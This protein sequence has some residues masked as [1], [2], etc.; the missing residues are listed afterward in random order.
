MPAFKVGD[1]I[2]LRDPITFGQ[3]DANGQPLVGA[4]FTSNEVVILAFE[5]PQA[6]GG[7]VYVAPATDFYSALLQGAGLLYTER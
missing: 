2:S 3:V 7:T 5:G 6:P 1:V 4:S